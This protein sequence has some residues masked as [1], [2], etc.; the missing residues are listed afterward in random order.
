MGDNKSK[1][2]SKCEEIKPLNSDYFGRRKD[3]KD[4]YTGQ[5]RTC[6]NKRM[7]VYTKKVRK[8]K[9]RTKNELLFSFMS[10]HMFKNMGFNEIKTLEREV[11]KLIEKGEYIPTITN[12]GLV[13][14]IEQERKRRM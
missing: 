13:Y 8:L 11:K 2:C 5:C 14:S 12:E 10:E 3:T 7:S 6:I 1:R 4:G 9:K